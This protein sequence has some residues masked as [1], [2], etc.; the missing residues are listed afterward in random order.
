[1]VATQ[2]HLKAI[3][4]EINWL[5]QTLSNR[6]ADY[7]ANQNSQP[8]DLTL[9]Q[10]NHSKQT[11]Y[12]KWIA[13]YKLT[14]NERL[15]LM[16]ALVAE[17]RPSQLDILLTPPADQHR[18]LFGGYLENNS[19]IPTLDSALF[20]L[21]GDNLLSRMQTE[22]QL[23][24]SSKLYQCWLLDKPS[25]EDGPKRHG[26]QILQLS[27]RCKHFLITGIDDDA[28]SEA[29]VA[30]EKI[31]SDLSIDELV[32][33]SHCKARLE[34]LQLWLDH[35]DKLSANSN[36]KR[37][38]PKGY[39]ALFYGPPGTGKSLTASVLG[40]QVGKP[41]YRV[42]LSQ[43]VS[44]YIGETEKNIDTLLSEAERY[45]WLL[46]FDEADALFGKRTDVN[47]SNDRYANQNTSFLLQRLET[48][49]NTIILAS[50]LKDNFDEAYIRR[51]HSVVYF[52]KPDSTQRSALWRLYLAPFDNPTLLQSD[53]IQSLATSFETTGAQIANICRSLALQQQAGTALTN[54]LVSHACHVE[55]SKQ[56]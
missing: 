39:R 10:P 46:F 12:G 37:L 53:V 47:S 24:H 49:H 51:F 9:A 44:K 22:P 28:I 29:Q 41:V 21:A 36:L 45:D 32:L 17:L 34:D 16:L 30:A 52:A 11:K 8:L 48:C 23:Q 3:E 7:Y 20:L 6:V 26:N 56:G 19:L 2:S 35:G 4:S 1:M 42:D 5:S 40:K 43:L 25:S 15:T 31:E 13:Q 55:L 33:S 50:N 38:L 18:S 14:T 27:A 54:H